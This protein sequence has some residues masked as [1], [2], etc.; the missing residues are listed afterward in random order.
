MTG[1]RAIVSGDEHRV[2]LPGNLNKVYDAMHGASRPE[3]VNVN[4]LGRGESPTGAAVLED[5]LPRLYL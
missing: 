2:S 3:L 5:N 1:R 4:D